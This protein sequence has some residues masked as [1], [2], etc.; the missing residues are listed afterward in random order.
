VRKP[1]ALRGLNVNHN[2]DLKKSLQECGYTRPV[3]AKPNGPA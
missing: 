2:H 3:P 1:P